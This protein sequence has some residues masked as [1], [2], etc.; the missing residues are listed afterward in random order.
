MIQGT[1]R[2]Q[3]RDELA[4][5]VPLTKDFELKN[6]LD[7]RDPDVRKRLNVTL[8]DITGNDYTKTHKIGNWARDNGFDGILAPSARNPS[9]YNMV[10]FGG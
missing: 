5:R 3:L 6:A 4:A 2:E 9:G 10:I 7:L 1:A 8:D